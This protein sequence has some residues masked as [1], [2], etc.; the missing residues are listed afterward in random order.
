MAGYTGIDAATVHT[1]VPASFSPNGLPNQ[2]SILFGY[3]Y[4]RE[5]GM[6][7][8]P[9]SDVALTGMWGTELVEE[10]LRDVGRLPEDWG[11]RPA[12]R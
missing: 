4:F 12:A 8:E 5:Q 2:E 10:V 9:V 6:I 3:Q 11:L 1:M 7:P